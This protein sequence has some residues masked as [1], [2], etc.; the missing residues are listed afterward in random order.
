MCTTFYNNFKKKRKEKKTGSWHVHIQ[1]FVE[2]QIRSGSSKWI[3]IAWQWAPYMQHTFHQHTHAHTRSLTSGCCVYKMTLRVCG[4]VP[5]SSA[6]T[7]QSL[8]TR[9][10]FVL[11]T[12]SW[13]TTPPER[14][15]E[16]EREHNENRKPILRWQKK[17]S[18]KDGL[19]GFATTVA[20]GN[21]L[22]CNEP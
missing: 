2:G 15:S 22:Y 12:A 14:E 8:L 1:C 3:F 19:C 16:R 10:W 6:S 17:K 13:V 5:V 11:G 7:E 18:G 20:L 9:P 21:G 4:C